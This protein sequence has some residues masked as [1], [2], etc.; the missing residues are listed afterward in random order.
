MQLSLVGFC[1]TAA[2]R[3]RLTLFHIGITVFFPAH[4]GFSSIKRKIVQFRYIFTERVNV[5]VALAA[6]G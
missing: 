6:N 2:V 5:V 1:L 3:P 4:Y